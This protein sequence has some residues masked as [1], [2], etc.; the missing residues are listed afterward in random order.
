MTVACFT[1]AG[2]SSDGAQLCWKQQVMKSDRP[3]C[4]LESVQEGEARI[5]GTHP[6]QRLPRLTGGAVLCGVL[7]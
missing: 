6:M 1:L 7:L 5:A 3:V 4:C 2:R